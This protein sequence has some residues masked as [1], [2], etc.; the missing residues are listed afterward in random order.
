MKRRFLNIWF[1]QWVYL[2]HLWVFT[3]SAGCISSVDMQIQERIWR[4]NIDN[5]TFF[6]LSFWR[7]YFNYRAYHFI[8]YRLYY[9]PYYYWPNIIGW[10]I[11]DI[12][13]IFYYD[14]QKYLWKQVH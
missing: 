4:K 14:L 9:N 13:K 6:N 2:H 3:T 11:R 12:S 8:K 1:Y 5:M 7:F 10:I